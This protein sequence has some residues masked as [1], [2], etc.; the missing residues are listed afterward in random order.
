MIAVILSSPLYIAAAL[1][2]SCFFYLFALAFYNLFLH[3]ARHI[4]GPILCRITPLVSLYHGMT[5]KRHLWVHSLH[6]QYGTHVHVTPSYVSINSS[7]ALHEIYGYSK[8]IRK[9]RFYTAFPAIKSNPNTHSGIDKVAHGRKRRILS[10]A[11]SESALKGMEDLIL[12]RIRFFQKQL[13]DAPKDVEGESRD[14]KGVVKMRNMANWFNYLTFDVLGFLCF[15]KSFEL[16][17]GTG[18]RH[19]PELVDRAAQRHF[20]CGLWLPLDSHHLDQ[21]VIPKITRDRWN[22]IMK[23]RQQATLRAKERT[24]LG[25]NARKDFFYYLLNASDPETGEKLTMPELWSESNVLMVAGSDTTSTSLAAAVFWLVRHP[26]ALKRLEAEI[27]S[28]FTDV[29]EIISGAKLN[30]CSYLKAVI[31]E[32]MRLSPAVPGG[33]PREVLSGGLTIDGKFIP[34]GVDVGTPI[35]SVHRLPDSYPRPDDFIP[36]RW[37]E[38]ETVPSIGSITKADVDKA[39]KAFCPF[40]IGPRGCIG[41]GLALMEMKI[42]LARLVWEFEVSIPEEQRLRK[43]GEDVE[44]GWEMDDHFVGTKKGPVVQLKRRA[45]SS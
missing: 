28:A 37:I 12:D 38:G 43:V 8:Q 7:A 13:L 2:G 24:D 45:M 19:L 9:A 17:E 34:A 36:E 6:E 33:L 40:S 42:T 14:E 32:A 3:P 15:G 20:L 5:G 1:L 18:N 31:D 22:F 35:Y 30:E 21:V 23:S 27:R 11:F 25:H 26:T 39:R 44:G 16:L 41:K 10:Q 29:E 4:P